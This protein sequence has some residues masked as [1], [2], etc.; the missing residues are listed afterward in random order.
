MKKLALI[1]LLGILS[2][3]SYSQKFGH[4]NSQEILSI[5]PQIN[6]I[7]GKLQDH[8]KQLESQLASMESEF[9]AM[10]QEYVENQESYDDLTKQDKEAEIRSLE[11][12]IQQFQQNAQKSIQQKQEEELEPILK[13]VNDAIKKVAEKGKYTYILDS[14]V[15]VLLYANESENILEKVKDELGL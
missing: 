8:I 15:G 13:Q 10:Y 2:I 7:E 6:S 3:S 4:I 12:R 9:Q 11:L 1:T 5:M 14:S